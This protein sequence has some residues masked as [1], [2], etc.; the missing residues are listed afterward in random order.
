MKCARLR[1]GLFL[2]IVMSTVACA[3]VSL[4]PETSLTPSP[5]ATPAATAAATVDAYVEERLQMIRDSV[6]HLDNGRRV[7]FF[8][9]PFVFENKV[10]SSAFRLYELLKILGAHHA[11]LRV[12]FRTYSHTSKQATTQNQRFHR[13]SSHSCLRHAPKYIANRESA[14]MFV[15]FHRECYSR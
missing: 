14:P 11:L 7:A 13:I 9:R 10:D 5:M 15:R 3:T 12:L 1:L 2:L 8:V 6:G 4:S